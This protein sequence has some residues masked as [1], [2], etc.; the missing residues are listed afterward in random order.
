MEASGKIVRIP[1]LCTIQDL[2]LFFTTDSALEAV[3]TWFRNICL[4]HSVASDA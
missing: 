4:N 1:S 2:A 3:K